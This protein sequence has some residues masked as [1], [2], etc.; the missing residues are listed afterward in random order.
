MKRDKR[1]NR[2][3]KVSGEPISI[4][5]IDK[6][7]WQILHIYYIRINQENPKNHLPRITKGEL[8]EKILK[9]YLKE[10]YDNK[11]FEDMYNKLNELLKK[12]RTSKKN[13]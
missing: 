6:V 7:I 8:I 10:K 5:P 11:E 13:K 1:K 9:D 4:K 12:K 2:K 3:K